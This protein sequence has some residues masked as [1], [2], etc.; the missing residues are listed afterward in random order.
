MKR[1]AE[2]FAI[3][4]VALGG[5]MLHYRVHPPFVSGKFL[6]SHALA[7][8]FSFVDVVVITTLLSFRKTVVYGFLFKGLFAILAV[9]LM[10]HFTI[11]DLSSK[12][13]TFLDWIFKSTLP[14]IFVALGGFFIAKA[15]YD[16]YFGRPE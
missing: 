13:P 8:I 15:I 10:S 16:S 6:F 3:F 7:S 12:N 14:D 5:G 11:A 9:V 4:F 1:R 2:V